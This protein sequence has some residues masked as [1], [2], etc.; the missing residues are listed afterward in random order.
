MLCYR[1]VILAC[2]GN[3]TIGLQVNFSLLGQ[4]STELLHFR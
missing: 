4:L 2:N 1:I 3:I